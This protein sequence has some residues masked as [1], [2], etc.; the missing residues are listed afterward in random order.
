MLDEAASQAWANL[1]LSMPSQWTQRHPSVPFFTLGMAAYLDAKSSPAMP[2]SIYAQRSVRDASNAIL[3]AH[4]EP[5]YGLLCLAIGQYF[6]VNAHL[7]ADQAALPGFHIHQPH[8]VFANEVASVHR[9][10]Q[11]QQVFPLESFEPHEVFTFTLPLSIPPGAGLNLWIKGEKQFH[12]YR[13][14][15][16][17]I[18]SGLQTHQ[19]ALCCSGTVAPRIALQGHGVLRKNTTALYW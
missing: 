2:S 5:L 7:I 15:E 10:L 12:P 6:G 13:A 9:D 11:F 17:V 4:F 14:G 8:P 1:V 16:L 3:M 19:A 18:H